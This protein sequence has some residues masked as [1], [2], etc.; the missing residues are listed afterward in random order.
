MWPS[1]LSVLSKVAGNTYQ[2]AIQGF[3]GSVGS[4][5][6]IIGLIIGGLLYEFI[7]VWSFLISAACIYT[8]FIISIRLR[9]KSFQEFL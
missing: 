5:S 3:A 4:L 2:G 9:A 8:A 7:G 1:V 6:S